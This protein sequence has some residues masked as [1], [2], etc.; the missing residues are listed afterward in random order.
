MA[1]INI[2]NE[3]SKNS[4]LLTTL[5]GVKYVLQR[6]TGIK[7]VR[8]STADKIKAQMKESGDDKFPY[9]WLEPSDGQT[10]RDQM[11]LRAIQRTGIRV[12][13][14]GATRNTSR[15]GFIFPIRLGMAFKYV[16]N[17]PIRMYRMLETFLVLSGI[18][19]L[20]FDTR[21]ANQLV[22]NTRIEIPDNATIP[23]ADTGDTTKPGGSEM[24]L[25]LVIHTHCGFFYDMSSVFASDPIIG[26]T[27]KSSMGDEDTASVQQ[28]VN[29][30]EF[31]DYET[32]LPEEFIS[33]VPKPT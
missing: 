9:A 6:E 27:L 17:D 10:V 16:D 29:E 19:M 21:F 32:Q 3:I 20:N 33:N 2:S 28:N 22:L 25:P 14:Y 1:R 24:E 4:L 13:T 15:A 8:L 7:N 30:S 5:N 12:G 26:Y 18:N 23:I 31:G 11:N